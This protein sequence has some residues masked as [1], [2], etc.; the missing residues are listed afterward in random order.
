MNIYDISQKTGVSTATVS[1]VIN[2]NSN[3]SEKTREKVLAAIE[4]YGYTPNVFA[5]GLGLNTMK[6]VG[7]MCA[8][9][10]DP[11]LAQTVY[12][13]EENLRAGNYDVLL[14]C[15]G[16][17]H[18]TKEKRMNMLL[19]KRVDAIIL[20]G[21]NY[22]E[23][24]LSDND[25]IIKAASEIPIMII[26][27]SINAP[28]VYCTVCDDYS[29]MYDVTNKMLS[30]GRK[31]PLYIYN[32]NSYSAVQ[33]MCGFRSAMKSYEMSVSEKNMLFIESDS[34][35]PRQPSVHEVR[36]AV[37]KYAEKLS[38]DCVIATDDIL[39]VGA[40]KYAKEAGYNIP[41]DI[42]VT[43]YN[44]FRIS[45]CCDPELTSVN[46]KL[47]VL[48]KHCVSSLLEIFAERG[49]FIPKQTVFS[50]EL[51]ERGTTNFKK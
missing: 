37:K 5:R 32:S 18:D 12:Y 17:D 34:A 44:N 46:N 9:S 40:L 39:A 33:K 10:S 30:S 29:A 15:T 14:S 31:K 50:C 22:V 26:N 16:Y 42:A 28:N 7:I 51:V 43:G 1:R 20:A 6:A 49:E 13:L 23:K 4:K 8:D 38:F 11:Y 41:N 19:S 3:V 45:E 35:N 25:Y 2:G 24:E 21:S 36:D 27:G 47:E 48:C